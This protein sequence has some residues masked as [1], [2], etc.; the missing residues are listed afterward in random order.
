MVVVAQSI[1]AM[2]YD[3]VVCTYDR[4]R[5]EREG[6]HYVLKIQ[7]D[8][9]IIYVDGGNISRENITQRYNL[10]STINIIFE[11]HIKGG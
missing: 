10:D 9:D 5:K 2:T 1:I 6:D 3:C 4:R 7:H 11:R 8:E